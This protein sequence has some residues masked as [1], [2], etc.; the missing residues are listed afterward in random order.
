MYIIYVYAYYMYMV[1]V[2]DNTNMNHS[3]DHSKTSSN[4]C[5]YMYERSV[6]KLTTCHVNSAVVNTS[7]EQL[8]HTTA[9][10]T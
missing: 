2:R 4:A 6:T 8:C 9:A 7:T 1:L 3:F 5:T 10:Y